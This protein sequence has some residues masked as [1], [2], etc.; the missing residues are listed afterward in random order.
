VLEAVDATMKSIRTALDRTSVDIASLEQQYAAIEQQINDINRAM[1]GLE[2]RDSM[3]IKPAN[4]SSRISY[5]MTTTWSSTYGPTK[6]HI[7]Q[8]GFALEGLDKVTK[9]L[10]DLH[11]NT[12]PSLQ[13]AIIEA[14]GPWTNG[15]PVITN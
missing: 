14:G 6:Q 13:K 9:Q 1:Y 8:L 2:S 4:I 7:E 12:I 10:A 3:G 15:A 5:A 11:K